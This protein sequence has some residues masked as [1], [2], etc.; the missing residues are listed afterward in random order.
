MGIDENALT[1][2]EQGLG[3]TLPGGYRTFLRHLGWLS[4]PTV[5]VFGA[6][7]DLPS[8]LDLRARSDEA[9]SDGVPPHLIPFAREPGGG[10]H[11]VDT[12]HEGPYESPVYDGVA[13]EPSAP[14]YGGHD[15]ASWMWM[16]LEDPSEAN[17][18]Q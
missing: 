14:A 18:G 9:R 12:S 7:A 17:A 8:E 2:L 3:V 6:G 16:H 13:G 1:E 15:F 11:F 4:A 10:I 5:E